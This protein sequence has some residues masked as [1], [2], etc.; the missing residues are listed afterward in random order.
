MLVLGA[1]LPKNLKIFIDNEMTR[2]KKGT[3]STLG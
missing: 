1:T 2:S 3:N